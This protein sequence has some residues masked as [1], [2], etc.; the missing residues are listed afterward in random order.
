VLDVIGIPHGTRRLLLRERLTHGHAVG[1]DFV[2]WAV[3]ALVDGYQSDSLA[4]L[5]GLDLGPAPSAFEAA[6]KF[7][8]ALKQMGVEI[9]SD[10]ALIH[11]YVC[12]VAK[13]VVDGELPPQEAVSRLHREVLTPLTHPHELMPWCLL[14]EG[15]HPDTHA[16]LEGDALDDAIRGCART[17]LDQGGVAE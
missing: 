13:Q 16:S 17:W 8:L 11:G 10:E 12:E 14:W 4:A 5:A 3:Q 9:P 15:L 2:D 1:R 6:E 7:H